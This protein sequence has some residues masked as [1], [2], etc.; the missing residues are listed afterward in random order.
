MNLLSCNRGVLGRIFFFFFGNKLPKNVLQVCVPICTLITETLKYFTFQ[1]LKAVD[2]KIQE[3]TFFCLFLA[4][5]VKLLYI[6]I[7]EKV[8]LRFPRF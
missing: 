8:F 7:Q 1:K 6:L 5:D 3:N 2:F 4:C